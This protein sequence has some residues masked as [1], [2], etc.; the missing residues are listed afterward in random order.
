MSVRTYTCT[1]ST[2]DKLIRGI[3]RWSKRGVQGGKVSVL[4]I[5]LH[6][7]YIIMSYI[8]YR[9]SLSEWYD[10]QRECNTRRTGECTIVHTQDCS[11]IRHSVHQR[12]EKM[13]K[14]RT[15][16][17]QGGPLCKAAV[18]AALGVGGGEVP[19]AVPLHNLLIIDVGVS[20]VWNPQFDLGIIANRHH[21][22]WGWKSDQKSNCKILQI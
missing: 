5:L 6:S 8:L 13:N 21:H 17:L 2:K 12:D 18:V 14:E 1:W 15:R 7:Q 20:I 9:T 10:D 3:T 16:W 11:R 22:K 19:K 4:Y